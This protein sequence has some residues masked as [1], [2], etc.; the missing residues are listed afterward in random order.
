W[1]TPS[2]TRWPSSASSTSS[3]PRVPRVSGRRSAMRAETTRRRV[4]RGRLRERGDQIINPLIALIR[5]VVADE[6]WWL[7]YACCEPGNRLRVAATRV[8]LLE[9]VEGDKI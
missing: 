7:I 4:R 3:C 9:V 5:P 2:S 1:S 6:G 8:T